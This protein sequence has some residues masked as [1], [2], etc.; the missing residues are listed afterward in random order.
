[1]RKVAFEAWGSRGWNAR[2]SLVEAAVRAT[3]RSFEA[4]ARRGREE[5]CRLPAGGASSRW[6]KS[7]QAQ[8]EMPRP[9]SQGSGNPGR[10]ETVAQVEGRRRAERCRVAVPHLIVAHR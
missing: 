7:R 5:P 3:S 10:L 2:A 9:P 6:S 4:R 8:H 1:M